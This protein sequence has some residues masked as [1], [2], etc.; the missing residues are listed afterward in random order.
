MERCIK[1]KNHRKLGYRKIT[2]FRPTTPVSVRDIEVDIVLNPIHQTLRV[3]RLECQDARAIRPILHW[4]NNG[5][6][7]RRGDDGVVTKAFIMMIGLGF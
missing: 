6:P 2:L 3:P 1:N 4:R 7:V 5:R